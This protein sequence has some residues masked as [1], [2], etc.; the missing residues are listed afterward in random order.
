MAIGGRLAMLTAA[1]ALMTSV[2][3]T[4]T[5]QTGGDPPSPASSSAV[6]ASSAPSVDPS[7]SAAE[8]ALTAYR[9]YLA[10]SMAANDAG[11]DWNRNLPELRRYIAEPLLSQVLSGLRGRAE[12]GAI[13]QGEIRSDP[14]VTG[15]NLGGSRPTVTVED[16][17]D[18]TNYVL[19]Y[20][21]NRSPV[22]VPDR[23][24][25]Q[26]G[27]GTVT[28]YEDGHWRVSSA[29]TYT[30]RAVLTR[31]A[32]SRSSAPDK[33][34]KIS[35][36]RLRPF[37]GGYRLSG[38]LLRQLLHLSAQ[39]LPGP[40]Q[41]ALS[42]L[43]GGRRLALRSLQVLEDVVERPEIAGVAGLEPDPSFVVGTPVQTP[44]DTYR[45]DQS[46]ARTQRR[47]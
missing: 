17:L 20:R 15:V 40:P 35:Y 9:R 3:C 22:P 43:R 1:A 10:A 8:A 47:R 33:F 39:P 45:L 44:M 24:R 26:Y 16:C 36:V 27:Q 6:P 32:P 30:N 28:R 37:S 31:P 5:D 21:S 25:R 11:D 46:S 2:G 42:L 12:H 18:Y 7:T 34:D 19:V 13:Y 38:D 14:K 23:N 29:T 4:G 41:R